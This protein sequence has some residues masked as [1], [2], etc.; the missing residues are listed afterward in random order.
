M[1]AIID[2]DQC[3]HLFDSHCHLNFTH[4]ENDRSEVLKQAA[5]AGVCQILIP[6]TRQSEWWS[7]MTQF[8]T[9]PV[10]MVIALGLHPSFMAEHSITALDELDQLLGKR[11]LAS[12]ISIVAIGET[13]VDFFDKAMNQQQKEQQLFLFK[14]HVQLAVKHELP[15]I[16]HGRKS[17]DEILH[18]LR[19][20]QPR[21]GGIIHAF[22]GSE[23][24]AQKYIKLG[25]KLGFGGGITY[26]RA[27]KTRHLAATLPLQHIVLETDAPDMPLFGYQGKRNEP[28]QVRQIAQCLAQLRGLSLQE[29]AAT[30]SNNCKTLFALPLGDT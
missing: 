4:F 20:F 23:Q 8:T 10:R 21:F 24:Q 22:S 18:I 25:F 30:T 16:I 15:M 6:A 3:L 5:N 12:S 9:G 29:V 13:G 1:P 11:Q 7:L 26:E 27:R 28:K 17:H 14:R 2:D 19:R